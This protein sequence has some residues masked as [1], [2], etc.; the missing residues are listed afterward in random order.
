MAFSSTSADH[1][2]FKLI[3]MRI[4]VWPLPTRF[5]LYVLTWQTLTVGSDYNMSF[6]NNLSP[7]Q[8]M[9]ENQKQCL[10]VTVT[11]GGSSL[12]S[13]PEV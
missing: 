12:D 13:G 2:A 8:I 9:N 10:H 7:G 4:I 6:T 11:I 3:N 5:T 1:Y